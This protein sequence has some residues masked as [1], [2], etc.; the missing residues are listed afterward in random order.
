[1]LD[2]VLM[3]D[4]FAGVL[5]LAAR[6]LPAPGDIMADESCSQPEGASCAAQQPESRV[7]CLVSG[8]GAEL[9]TAVAV[10]TGF[11]SRVALGQQK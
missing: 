5:E 1:M 9:R 2:V 4:P 8:E 11:P 7:I 10:R 3:S 6:P